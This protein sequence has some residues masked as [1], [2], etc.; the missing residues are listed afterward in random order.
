M[1]YAV[2]MDSGAMIYIPS[3]IKSCSGI[4][5]LMGGD[6]QTQKQLG[7]RIKAFYFFKIRN[8]G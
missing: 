7:D 3:F 5:E 1:K 6:S 4:Q 8:V 2:D